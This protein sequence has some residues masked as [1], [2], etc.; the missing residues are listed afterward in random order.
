MEVTFKVCPSLIDLEHVIYLDFESTDKPRYKEEQMPY[1]IQFTAMSHEQTMFDSMITPRNQ[2]FEIH[3]EAYDIHG[4]S[5][6]DLLELPL[7]KRPYLDQVWNQFLEWIKTLAIAPD[8]RI[9]LCAYNGFG[10]DFRVLIHNL[11][12]FGIKIAL[13]C[14]L[15]DPWLDMI[16]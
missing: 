16:V 5:K 9:I 13:D 15:I 7:E 8:N 14:W 12:E 10:F 2:D 1:I 11:E 3:P 6:D 4:W